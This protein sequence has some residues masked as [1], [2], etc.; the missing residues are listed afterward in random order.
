MTYTPV[1]PTLSQT[2]RQ[3][4]NDFL[5]AFLVAFMAAHPTVV[6]KQWS[7][8]PASLTG[9]GPFVYLGDITE[10]L[11]HDSGTRQTVFSGTLGYVDVLADPQ[12]TNTR[13]NTF[14]D[15]M[16]DWF[17]ANVHVNSSGRDE[18]HQ[19]Q[20]TEGSIGQGPIA[21]AAIL[22]HWKWTVLEGRI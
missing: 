13:M 7:E 8:L 4:I 22:I 18:L 5:G 6:R 20:T 3:D 19:T 17:S 12:E 11:L 1:V 16:R 2:N 10:D 21:Y 9:E 15:F 14:A